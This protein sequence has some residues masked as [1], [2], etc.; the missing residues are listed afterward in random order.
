MNRIHFKLLT[1]NDTIFDKNIVSCIMPSVDGEM[2]VL[3]G[4]EEMVVGLKEGRIIITTDSEELIYKISSGVAYI[5]G[6][7]C[8]VM[9]DIANPL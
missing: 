7:S 8:L 6:K 4:H 2:G 9:V 1:P 5:D 3:Y